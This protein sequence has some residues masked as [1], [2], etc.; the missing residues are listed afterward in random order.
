MRQL[1]GDQTLEFGDEL[2]ATFRRQI[3]LEQFDGDEP[4]ASRVIGTK[5]R[6]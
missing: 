4:L 5:D 6:S 3:E 2:M 1:G